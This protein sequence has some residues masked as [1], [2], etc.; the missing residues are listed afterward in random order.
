MNFH[1]LLWHQYANQGV[2][3]TGPNEIMLTDEKISHH[4]FHEMALLPLAENSVFC[5]VKYPGMLTGMSLFRGPES[6]TGE[7][8]SDTIAN[9]NNDKLDG[10]ITLDS[11][12]GYPYLPG[13]TVKG[14]L[15]T[16]FRENPEFAG[17]II[18][19]AL[20]NTGEWSIEEIA[21]FET[22]VFGNRNVESEG[23]DVEADISQGEDSFLDAYPVTADPGISAQ[24]LDLET[25]AVPK[26]DTPKGWEQLRQAN[27][28]SFLK[29]RPGVIFQFRF[30]GEDIELSSGRMITI[31]QRTRI[32]GRI[33]EIMG[34]GAK[35]NSGYGNLERVN[36]PLRNRRDTQ[37]QEQEVQKTKE[38]APKQTNQQD[39]MFAGLLGKFGAREQNRNNRNDRNNH[40][41]KG[42]K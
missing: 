32:Y 39:D 33:L 31:K 24:L 28:L 12:T 19:D 7:Q 3:G 17:A 25:L 15:R 13:S 8:N 20:K 41:N 26:S 40:S 9:V 4:I 27:V 37:R 22:R 38:Q 6:E 34:A 35:T 30:L 2:Y 29:I 23:Q 18:Q 11:V 16:P 14:I 10:G 5:K 21:E 1:Y 42:R 36:D